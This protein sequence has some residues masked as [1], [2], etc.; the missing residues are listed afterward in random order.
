MG[1]HDNSFKV[2]H[3]NAAGIDVGSRSHMVAVNQSR[4]D[5]REFGIYTKDHEELITYLYAEGI[6]TIAM[7]STGSY[8]QTLFSSLQAA[9]FEV[10]LVPGS[11]TKNVKGRKTDVL[12]CMWIQK[13]HSLGLLSGSLQLTDTFQQL[14]T[15]YYHR[16]HLVEQ[17]ARYTSKMQKALR[18]MNIKLDVAINDITGQSG[19]AVIE[20]IISGVR[21]PESLSALVS[22]RVK[23]SR[24]EI[25]N[26]L[27]G[28]WRDE[29]LFELGACLEFY[30]LYEHKIKECDQVI[31]EL[32]IKFAPEREITEAEHK[33]LRA[34]KKRRDK[35]APSFDLSHLSF[36]YF[37][38]DLFAINGISY[39]AVLCL[40][41]NMGHDLHKFPSAKSFASWLGLVPNNKISGG[42]IISNRTASGKNYIAKA[43]RHAANSIGNQKDHELTPF[44]KRIAFRKGRIAAIIATARKLAVIIWNMI[45]KQEPYKREMV[46]VT[47]ARQKSLKI[48]QIEKKISALGLSKEEL[49]KMFTKSSLSAI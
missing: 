30:R 25:T 35:H 11:Q 21:D 38:T 20:A 22:S 4:E 37:N 48:R 46:E 44:F 16:S 49:G 29:L 7:E 13:L 24:E 5:V 17:S 8:W 9:G 14:R 39:N 34:N 42:R 43:L 41:T 12:D 31:Q 45:I 36:S 40:L 10:V 23:K 32:L 27:H 6:M 2:I 18:L 15:Y 19:M 47:S 3:P 33:N 28:W 1:K 26:S